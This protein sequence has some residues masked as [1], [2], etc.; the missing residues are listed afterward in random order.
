MRRINVIF[1]EGIWN[2]FAWKHKDDDSPHYTFPHSFITKPF[3]WWITNGNKKKHLKKEG[4][5]WGTFKLNPDRWQHFIQSLTLKL[6]CPLLFF[7]KRAVR[8]STTILYSNIE[9]I[10]YGNKSYEAPFTFLDFL[11]N[12]FPKLIQFSA[13]LV[14]PVSWIY[15]F[16]KLMEW[17]VK[18]GFQWCVVLINTLRRHAS[19]LSPSFLVE[20][21]CK[22]NYA[23]RQ[24]QQ[25]GAMV[26]PRA[27]PPVWL[28]IIL[29]HWCKKTRYKT[30]LV[31]QQ[32]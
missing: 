21:T 32:D 14:I 12:W 28:H 26:D 8:Q 6:P 27:A 20:I 17:W 13:K 1:H 7:L 29:S 22:S 3:W 2:N 5:R 23:T 10:S 16:T 19:S 25:S 18:S 11:Q 30:M 4:W 31:C 24:L 15:R 9:K